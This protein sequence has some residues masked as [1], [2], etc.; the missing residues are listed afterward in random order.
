MDYTEK[1]EIPRFALPTGSN[2]IKALSFGSNDIQRDK[3]LAILQAHANFKKQYS[4]KGAV[5]K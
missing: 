3:A 4:Q 2:A 5:S 1:V